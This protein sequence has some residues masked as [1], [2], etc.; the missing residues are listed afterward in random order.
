MPKERL[1]S[2][3][4]RQQIIEKAA[5]I[6]AA[7]GLDGARTRQI[8]EACGINEATLYKHFPSKKA[9][10]MAAMTRFHEK[11]IIGWHKAVEAEPDGLA[12]LR[13][14][15]ELGLPGLYG[16]PEFC[17]SLLHQLAA[18]IQDEAAREA[19]TQWITRSYDF[20]RQLI[21]RGIEDGSLRPDLDADRYTFLLSGIGWAC[22]VSVAL[23]LGDRFAIERAQRVCE[24]VMNCMAATDEESE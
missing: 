20:R 7:H 12:A 21:E 9:L 18:A 6:F 15:V 14:L 4:R 3:E 24:E 11:T 10:F 13:R 1:S 2:G 22:A 17:T 8:A 23:G 19:V 16:D 5:E